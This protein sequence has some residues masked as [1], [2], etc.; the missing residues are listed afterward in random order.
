M[1]DFF[2]CDLLGFR[3]REFPAKSGKKTW[4]FI[5]DQRFYAGTITWTVLIKNYQGKPSITFVQK[6]PMSSQYTM[7]KGGEQVTLL[8]NVLV[9][10]SALFPVFLIIKS[11][12]A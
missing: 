1:F 8:T 2:V 5:V 11:H 9:N 12:G 7:I 4:A 6:S 3:A 10:L